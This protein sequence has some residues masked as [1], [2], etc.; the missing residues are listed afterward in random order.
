MTNF[1]FI[2][3]DVNTTNNALFA[4]CTSQFLG[5]SV[6]AVSSLPNSPIFFIKLAR[7]NFLI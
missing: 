2:G 7:T 1:V 5:R 4:S 3:N 6:C